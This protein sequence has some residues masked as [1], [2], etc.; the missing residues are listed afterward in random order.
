MVPHPKIIIPI[1]INV[2]IDLHIII[3]MNIE[4]YI[5]YYLLSIRYS[6]L[7]IPYW[8]FPIGYSLLTMCIVVRALHQALRKLEPPP[9][10]LW[11]P[12]TLG[13]KIAYFTRKTTYS[14]RK[15]DIIDGNKWLIY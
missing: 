13:S 1:D 9:P 14:N 4:Y 3:N 7:A 10:P 5:K 15:F 6:L 11:A 12:C 2:N 8:L